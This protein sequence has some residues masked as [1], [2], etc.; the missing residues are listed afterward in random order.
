MF[1]AD[2]GV[3]P[4]LP[5][6]SLRAPRVA[7]AVS[8]LSWPLL[9]PR[10]P[11]AVVCV[12]ALYF[13]LAANGPL[14]VELARIFRAPSLWLPAALA[15][16]WLLLSGLVAVLAFSA[17][18][19]FMKPLWMALI[20]LAVVV[21]YY[22][23]IYHVAMDPGMVANVLH[24]DAAEARE[25]L[26]WQLLMQLLLIAGPMIAWL[27]RVPIMRRSIRANAWRNAALLALALVA[28]GACV[29]TTSNKLAPLMRNHDQ[30][31][32]FMNPLAA[33]WSAGVAVARP[34]RRRPMPL[35]LI[36]PGTTL[37]A[38][39]A[40]DARPPL[41]LL[42][43][44]E[45]ARADHF[46]LNGYPRDTT[47]G[48]A[49]HRVLSWRNVTSC[50]TSTLASLPCMFSPLTRSEFEARTR[51][52]ENLLDVLQAAGLA[53]LW[54][55]NQSGGCKG[56]CARVPHVQ[57]NDPVAHPTL[58]EAGDCVDEVLLAGIDER[59]T[60]LPPEHRA[61][62]VVLVL[63]QMGSHG[64]AYARRSPPAAKRYAP[65]CRSTV[66]GDCSHPELINAY[67]NSIAYTDQVLT[68]AI[69]WLQTRSNAF[70]T[71]LLYVS[72]HGESLGEYG[73]YLHG[74]PWRIAPSAQ[75]QVP[76]VAWL[77]GGLAQR[78]AL[79]SAC[80]RRTLD[81]PLSHDHL[82]HTVLGLL[83]VH[84]ATYRRELDAFAAC[85]SWTGS[86]PTNAMGLY[87][88]RS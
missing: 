18:S 23:G 37:G 61:H 50:G 3:A 13:L 57:V 62:G 59:L 64:P 66:P 75:K 22:A 48:L 53:V 7:G 56:V 32:Y 36:T 38:G 5:S 2:P 87:G 71:G 28:A 31:R 19:R 25:L 73:L 84:N 68:R 51:D 14:W 43:V 72:D 47:P 86:E 88:D 29:G 39:H 85:R 6:G 24:T 34:L 11:Q 17:W 67:D 63:H 45:T 35:A 26:G 41:F 52:T 8:T 16:A 27:W 79:D 74:A 69:D 80:L 42:V 55:D 81:T 83:D 40:T 70:A 60:S 82:F 21:Q 44:G 33:L 58:C 49:R 65:E 54:L 30:L 10:S 1:E 77:Q 78:S 4:L 9:K 46:A 12:L 76:M 20:V 15:M